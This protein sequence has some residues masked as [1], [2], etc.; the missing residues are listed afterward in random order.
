M[1]ELHILFIGAGQLGGH[2]L[3]LLLRVPGKRQ[4]LVAGRNLET[5][6][7]R[8]NLSMLAAL[9]LSYTPQV[10]CIQLDLSN[11]EHTATILSRLFSILKN[12]PVS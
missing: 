2:I 10:D 8:V 7:P 11:I 1:K 9:Q 6:H 5:L 4:F 12:Q 3:D